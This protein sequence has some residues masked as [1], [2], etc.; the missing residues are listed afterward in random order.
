[1]AHRG[2]R[3]RPGVPVRL[4]VFKNS[5]SFASHPTRDER[6]QALAT[7]SEASVASLPELRSSYRRLNPLTHR[8]CDER[9]CWLIWNPEERLFI[10][11]CQTF[12]IRTKRRGR[13]KRTS[14]R[15]PYLPW[16]IREVVE[17][18]L[19]AFF[20]LLLIAKKKHFNLF[21]VY[22]ASPQKVAGSLIFKAVNQIHLEKLQAHD[23]IF[24]RDEFCRTDWRHLRSKRRD[25]WRPF[26]YDWTGS[27]CWRINSGS[28]SVVSATSM[29]LS[30]E[31]NISPLKQ[32]Q[33]NY[34]N[35]FF[36]T[37]DM[38]NRQWKKSGWL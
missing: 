13:R 9:P 16:V 31:D 32:K 18:A 5:C 29:V 12:K 17:T 14:V 26:S 38:L 24:S 15:P 11:Q 3:R 20:F 10:C 1:M 2:Q 7:G 34:L 30:E 28:R 4:A 19:L 25:I 35:Y 37:Y 6:T 27:Y 8:P 21:S 23:A 33:K 22:S 36:S